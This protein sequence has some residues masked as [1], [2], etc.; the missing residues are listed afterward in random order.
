MV[1]RDQRYSSHG[2]RLGAANVLKTKGSLWPTIASLDDWR[3]L[4]FSGY[5]DLTPE[6]DRDMSRLLIETEDLESYL[7][8]EVRTLGARSQLPVPICVCHWASGARSLP[9]GY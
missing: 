9:D 7:G 4:A 2:L 3:S 5:V 1:A 8:D 6:L